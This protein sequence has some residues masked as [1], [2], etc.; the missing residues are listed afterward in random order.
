M[1][2]EGECPLLKCRHD[3]LAMGVSKAPADYQS[4]WPKE[5]L[6]ATTETNLLEEPTAK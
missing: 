4:W 1:F 6:T 3:R 5:K 2:A